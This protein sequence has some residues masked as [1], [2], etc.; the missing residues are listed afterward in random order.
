M[1]MT[2]DDYPI[3]GTGAEESFLQTIPSWR[4]GQPE[5]AADVVQYLAS[6]E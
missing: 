6:G 2:T 4:A 1:A 5:D 3:M